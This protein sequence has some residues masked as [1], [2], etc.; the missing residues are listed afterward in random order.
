MTALRQLGFSIDVIIKIFIIYGGL[1]V[2]L[3]IIFN[4][5][6]VLILRAI[7]GQD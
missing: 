7:N 1:S 3:V 2:A 4:S 6:E 5:A